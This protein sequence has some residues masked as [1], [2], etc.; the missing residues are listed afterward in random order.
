MTVTAGKKCG[1]NEVVRARL[2]IRSPKVAAHR[3]NLFYFCTVALSLVGVFFNRAEFV[4][5]SR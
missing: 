5:A 1:P 3:G 2:K 4:A